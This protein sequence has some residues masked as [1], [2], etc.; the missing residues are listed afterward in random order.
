MSIYD[1]DELENMNVV[2]FETQIGTRKVRFTTPRGKCKAT[3]DLGEGR[4]REWEERKG[5]G[6]SGATLVSKGAGLTTGT[7]TIE[8]FPDTEE[9]RKLLRLD[10]ESF[11]AMVGSPPQGSP[12]K[13][14]TINHPIAMSMST[15]MVACVFLNDPPIKHDDVIDLCTD[16]FKIKEF[17]KQLPTLSATTAPGGASPDGQAKD[18]LDIE[19][20]AK[21]TELGNLS[22]EA[23]LTAAP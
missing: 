1:S 18:A 22:V 10:R 2:R 17:R 5:P 12:D 14:F 20:S 21:S 9:E 11:A 7:I 16:V 8:Y 13:A 6:L 4:P 3:L 19:L 23:G 15:P